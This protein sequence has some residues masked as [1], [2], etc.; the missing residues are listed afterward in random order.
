MKDQRNKKLNTQ[1]LKRLLKDLVSHK[2]LSLGALA[3]TIL[4]SLG[5]ILSP[6]IL[7]E[8]TN[9]LFTGLIA[10]VKGL[11]QI[12]YQGVARVL[13]TVIALNGFSTLFGSAQGYLMAT[14]TERVNY[15][16]KKDMLAKVN[17]L[18]L[19]YFESKPVGESLSII[20]NDSET[21]GSALAQTA[22]NL[23]TAIVTMVGMAIVIFF[24]NVPMALVVMTSIPISMVLVSILVRYTQKYFRSQQ[25]I[26][27]NLTGLVEETYAGINVVKAYNKEKETAENF[28]HQSQS[29]RESGWKAIFFSGVLFPLME[30]INNLSYVLIVIIGAN[31]AIKGLIEIGLIQ[32]FIQYSNRFYNPIITISQSVTLMQNISASGERIYGFIDLEEEDQHDGEILD[33][34]KLD[35]YV[36]TENVKFGY[37]PGQSIINDFSVKV[38]PGQKVAIVGPTGAGKSTIVKLFM[39]FY[40]VNAGKILLDGKNI[41]D[42]SRASYQQ[43]TSMVLQ[44]TWLFKGSIM[45]NVRYGRIGASDEEVIQACKSARVHHYITSLPGGYN[46]E[47]NEDASNVSQGQKQLLTIARALLADRP[48][49][50]LDEATSSV[51]TRTEVLIQDAMDKL[52]EGRTS[53]VIAHRLST[54]KNSDIILYMENGDVVE[55][56]SHDE[57]MALGGKYAALYNSQFAA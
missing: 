17:K 12:D 54:I 22:G 36:E 41:S 1:V 34:D 43:S 5:T 47:L 31:F 32:A 28:V 3:C 16:L 9:L 46:F 53:F 20:I 24:M 2:A 4:G 23:L 37:V 21:L 26:L 27:G 35:G 56:G 38:K 51:D 57:L 49:L 33:V 50:I 7:A 30:F 55:Q 14:L 42:Y 52:M 19:S 11:G 45:D 39:R 48:I 18:P 25:R 13:V 10:T 44:D 15:R 29:I 6:L 40:D 8:A